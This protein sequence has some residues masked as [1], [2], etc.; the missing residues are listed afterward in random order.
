MIFGGM[1]LLGFLEAVLNSRP[2]CELSVI[3]GTVK[4]ISRFPFS[5]PRSFSNVV[6]VCVAVH[7]V[8]EADLER[9]W[10]E[11]TTH[12]TEAAAPENGQMCS[13][14]QDS[15][16]L[17]SSRDHLWSEEFSQ[18]MDPFT[19]YRGICSGIVVSAVVSVVVSWYLRWYRDICSGIGVSAVVSWYLQWYRGIGA[20]LNKTI[21]RCF[22]CIRCVKCQY[23][24]NIYN[25][26]LRKLSSIWATKCRGYCQ[27]L[28]LESICNMV[29][30]IAYQ[31]Q[32]DNPMSG[33]E[34]ALAEGKKK[35]EL[36]DVPSAVLCFEVAVQRDE[37]CAEAWFLLGTSQA[38]NEQDC[39]AIPALKKCMALDPD[40]LPALMTLASSYTNEGHQF[41]ACNVLKTWLQQNVKYSN[42][43]PEH[44]RSKDHAKS[45][46]LSAYLSRD[47]CT[48]LQGLFL[49]AARQNPVGTI[50]PDVQSGLGVLFNLTNEYDKA[51]DCFRT[52][53]QVRH[54]DFRLWNRLGATLANGNRS[55]EAV[56]AYHH[57]LQLSPGFIR[58]R[59]NLGIS[60]I[61]LTAYREAAEHLLTALNQ[62][63]AGVDMEGRSAFRNMSSTIWTTLRLV[64]ALLDRR[65]LYDAVD[66]RRRGLK[67]IV[68][69]TLLASGSLHKLSPALVA[70]IAKLNHREKAQ[71][72][73]HLQDPVTPEV[74]KD[75]FA[76]PVCTGLAEYPCYPSPNSSANISTQACSTCINF[77]TTQG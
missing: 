26:R 50:D 14:L 64:V 44:L 67:E 40:N 1:G 4:G 9:A 41:Q 20:T 61:N 63:A 32:R 69:L 21:G 24:Y 48:E 34:D 39:A 57:A 28:V 65:D 54:D 10:S 18:I 68:K 27:T 74:P 46:V 66:S 52:A 71:T 56:E 51:A 17:H 58:A 35:L 60:C 33:L 19:W 75:L 11:V 43:V 3:V 73:L 5:S 13:L 29:A 7:E 59:Y 23:N 25:A 45:S 31:F 36:G 16:E 15:T 72:L 37:H 38:E 77:I 47:M 8:H 53:L 70:S 12:G 6:L 42:L 2:L 49:E 76:D 22:L 30:A 55:E 62:Q